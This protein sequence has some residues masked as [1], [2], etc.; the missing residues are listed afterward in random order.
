MACFKLNTIFEKHTLVFD[1]VILGHFTG[2]LCL[3]LCL[4]IKLVFEINIIH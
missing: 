1:R 3:K 2:F 4:K